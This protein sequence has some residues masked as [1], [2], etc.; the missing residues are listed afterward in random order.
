VV[1]L[2]DVAT[3]ALEKRPPVEAESLLA[4]LHGRR[5]G[6]FYRDDPLTDADVEKLIEAAS[7]APSSCNRRPVRA[8]VVRDDE[9]I[10]AVRRRAERHY[11][12]LLRLFRLPGFG[13]IWR[14]GGWPQDQLDQLTRNFTKLTTP[15][16]MPRQADDPLLYG[17]RTLIAFVSSKAEREGVGDAWLAAANAM[18]VAETSGIAT[19]FNGWTGIAARRD[20]ELRRL[21]ALTD[22]ERVVCMLTAGYPKLR[23]RRSAPRR[24]MPTT[25]IGTPAEGVGEHVAAA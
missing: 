15:Q 20:A 3:I 8:V 11:H 7:L 14:L 5:S 6:R 13:L 16:K 4:L 25:L 1:G 12:H 10:A 23:Y 22:E 24:A 19:C 21:L 17:A 9:V 18:L 2:E